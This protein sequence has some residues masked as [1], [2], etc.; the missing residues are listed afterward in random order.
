MNRTYCATA[1]VYNEDYSV[2]F[3][4][5]L[6]GEVFYTSLLGY[7]FPIKFYKEGDHLMALFKPK[8]SITRGKYYLRLEAELILDYTTDTVEGVKSIPSISVAKEH[9]HLLAKKIDFY[10]K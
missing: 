10:Y 9:E 6:V 3:L 4:D 1:F 7:R 2:D 5:S 8:K